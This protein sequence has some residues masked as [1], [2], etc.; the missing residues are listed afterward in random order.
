MSAT[1][2]GLCLLSLAFVP[3][4]HAESYLSL[5]G[6]LL[7]RAPKLD[8]QVLE[9]ALQATQCA[10]ASGIDAPERLAVIDFSLPSDKKRLWVFDLESGSLLLTEL[11]AHG[12]NTGNRVAQN[13]S[14]KVGSHQSSIGLFQACK[15]FCQFIN[16][17]VDLLILI[18]SKGHIHHGI[19]FRVC[20]R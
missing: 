16:L 15:H 13:F 7:P 17:T 19:P 18:L 10:V 11:V 3:L 6:E 5:A 4:S 12:K 9:N 14:N 2:I 1:R 20:N 8:R